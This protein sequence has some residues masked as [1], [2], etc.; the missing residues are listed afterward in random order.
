MTE[1][2]YLAAIPDAWEI[3]GVR[4]RPFSLGHVILLHRIESPFIRG[5][6]ATN[7]PNFDDLALAVL[8]CSESYEVGLEILENPNLPKILHHWANQLTGLDRWSVRLGFRK[9]TPLD[10][11][12]VAI[13]FSDY[14]DAHSKIPNYEF[15]PGD[16]KEIHCPEVQ[17]VKVSLMRE[18]H[19]PEAVLLDRCW[20]LCLW[21]YTTLRA[22]SGGVKLISDE[23]MKARNDARLLA[24]ELF[25]KLQAG[26]VKIPGGK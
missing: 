6:D 2:F 11:P 13:E 3:L 25:A 20:G 5:W 19:I 17:L 24:N 26:T 8:L 18:M 12:T 15:N 10:F 23:D 7:P 1:P 4:L 9:A 22:M 16:F 14:I 21:D